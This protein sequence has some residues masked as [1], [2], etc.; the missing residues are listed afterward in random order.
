MLIAFDHDTASQARNDMLNS[1]LDRPVQIRA[2]SAQ[3]VL[4]SKAK[5]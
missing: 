5:P 1:L 4:W 3:V 2:D